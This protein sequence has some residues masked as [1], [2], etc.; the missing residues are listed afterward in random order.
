M[1][2]RRSTT[3]HRPRQRKGNPTRIRPNKGSGT[4]TTSSLKAKSNVT[5]CKQTMQSYGHAYNDIYNENMAN[6][7]LLGAKDSRHN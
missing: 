2:Q 5:C 3:V 6:P 1:T 4:K 7:Y